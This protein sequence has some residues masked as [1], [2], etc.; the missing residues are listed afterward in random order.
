M[1]GR[2]FS[3]HPIFDL[4]N[5]F[6]ECPVL[7]SRIYTRLYTASLKNRLTNRPR[8]PNNFPIC[9]SRGKK[10]GNLVFLY[11]SMHINYLNDHSRHNYFLQAI[12]FLIK[13]EFQQL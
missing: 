1:Y 7:D 9:L 4:L 5:V 3:M 10:D 2:Q 6:S 8:S 12:S 11:T 13:Q